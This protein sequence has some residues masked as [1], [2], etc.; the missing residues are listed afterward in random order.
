MNKRNKEA[1]AK[2][3][4]KFDWGLLVCSLIALVAIPYGVIVGAVY[5]MKTEVPRIASELINKAGESPVK[6]V[7]TVAPDWG[8]IFLQA[9]IIYVLLM[10]SCV[11]AVHLAKKHPLIEDLLDALSLIGLA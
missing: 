7:A 3:S 5:F 1:Q 2:D 10:A 6:E 11:A 8:A 9:I 4:D